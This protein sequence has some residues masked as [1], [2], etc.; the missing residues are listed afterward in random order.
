MIAVTATQAYEVVRHGT[1]RNRQ[2]GAF[3]FVFAIAALLLTMVAPLTSPAAA[4]WS[5]PRTVYFDETG[6]TLDQVFLD[7]WRDS[8]GANAFGYPI[9]PEITLDNDHVVQYME[10]ARFEYWPE[11]DAD[12]KHFHIG[13]IGEEL[14]PINLQ[15]SIA[16]WSSTGSTAPTTRSEDTLAIAKAWLPLSESAVSADARFIEAT[17][18]TVSGDFQSFWEN[19]GEAS[20]LGNPISETYVSGTTTFQVFENGQLAQKKDGEVEMVPVGKVLADRYNIDQRAQG[21][22]DIPTYSEELFV[23]P[24]EP[25]PNAPGNYIEGGGAVSIDINL[26]AQYMVVYQG[27]TVIGETYIST[28][29]AGFETPPGSFYVNTKY[30]SDDMEGVLG[31][32]YYNVPQVPDVMYFTDVGHAI[33]GAYWHNNFGSPMSHGC[34]NVPLGFAEWLYSISPVGT[35]VTIHY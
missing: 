33:H 7:V 4:E 5:A 23:P 2:R 22:G 27:N 20:Y 14:R 15:R 28:G 17:G 13:K 18:H 31:G 1:H 10:Y 21:Q 8:G 34:V 19:T 32:E 6:Q 26:S 35:L 9:S 30:I 25:E 16:T 11:G 29:R 24:P 12:G 3:A